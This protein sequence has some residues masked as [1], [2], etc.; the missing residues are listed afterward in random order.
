MKPYAEL[1]VQGQEAR[2]A[3]LRV[4]LDSIHA[5]A[6]CKPHTQEWFKARDAVTEA[7]MSLADSIRGETK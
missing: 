5:E 2:I 7:A 3:L 6:R 4:L 1:R